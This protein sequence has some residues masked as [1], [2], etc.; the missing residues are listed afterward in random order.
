MGKESSLLRDDPRLKKAKPKAMVG[1][2]SYQGP[3]WIR[4]RVTSDVVRLMRIRMLTFLEGFGFF[5]A[6]ICVKSP[7]F[8]HVLTYFLPFILLVGES[9]L[10]Q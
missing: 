7:L 10:F 6:K 5:G 1:P 8:Y 3:M 9:K 2:G 4:L